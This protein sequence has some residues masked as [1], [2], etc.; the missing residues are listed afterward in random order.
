MFMRDTA[1]GVNINK[2]FDRRPPSKKDSTELN[3]DIRDKEVRL[4]G[5]DGEQLGI[6]SSREAFAIALEKKMDLVKIAP[7]ATP[8]VCKIMDYG[9]FRYEQQKKEREAKKNQK[10]VTIKEIRLSLNIEKHDMETKA[11]GALKFLKEGDKVKVSLR[12]RGRE[13]A[14]SGFATEVINRFLETLGEDI[15]IIETQPKLEGKSVTAILSPK[16]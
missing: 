6:L 2:K 8:P 16:N 5:P 3:E 11:K 14:N 10:T 15:A 1:G 12:L 7:Q 9:K 4:I 13:L